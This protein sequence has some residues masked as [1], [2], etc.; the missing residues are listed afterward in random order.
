MSFDEFLSQGWADHAADP[1]GVWD[2]LPRA[3]A[4]VEQPRHGAAL[5]GLAAHVAGEHLGRFDD[6]VA[7]LEDLAGLP[8][9]DAATPEAKAVRRLEAALHLCAG[10]KAEAARCEAQGRS[11]GS[12]PGASDRIRVLATAAAALAGQGRAEMALRWLEDA[13]TLAAYGPGKEDPAARALAV[14]GNNLAVALEQKAE[15]TPQERRLMLL[16]ARTGRRW[17]EVAGG[18]REVERA[19][20]R[21]AMSHL[22]AGD[23]ASVALRHARAC[24]SIVK[25]NGAEPG[26]AFFAKEVLARAHAAAGDRAAAHRARDDA[27]ALLPRVEDEGFRSFCAAELASLDRA[28]A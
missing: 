1:R 12:L 7:F 24:E 13:R 5:A 28:L 14:A 26:E 9:W 18:W 19:E 15:R 20:Y 8:G 11:G 2:R 21:L 6:G 22:K 17:W 25:E 27:A 16:A 4:L 23:P 3:L 10:R